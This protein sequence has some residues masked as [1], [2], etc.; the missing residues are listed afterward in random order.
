MDDSLPQTSKFLEFLYFYK[1]ANFETLLIFLIQQFQKFDYF[2][3]SSI[4]EIWCIEIVIEIVW[5]G[6]FL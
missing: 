3:I 2:M 5:F 1:L 6:K 4:M